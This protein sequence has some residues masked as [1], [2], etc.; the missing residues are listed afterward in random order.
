MRYPLYA[1]SA[2]AMVLAGCAGSAWQVTGMSPGQLRAVSDRDLC[3][4]YTFRGTYSGATPT[5]ESEVRRRG[6][7]CGYAAVE[8]DRAR[9][10]SQ[11]LMLWG[12][13]TMK[14]AQQR[15]VYPAPA[16][17]PPMQPCRRELVPGAGWVVHC[18]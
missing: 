8:N 12:L 13:D 6:L 11:D 10:R 4:T 3:H 9:Q 18:P 15:Q 1:V 17:A 5:V 2:V 16:V 14:D 7:D